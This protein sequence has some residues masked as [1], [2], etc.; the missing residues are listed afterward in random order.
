MSVEALAYVKMLEL[1]ERESTATRFVMYVLGENT[2]NDS[3]RCRLSQDQIAF[4][5]GRMSVRTLRR[6]LDTLSGIERAADGS[7]SVVE[8]V[9]IKRHPQFDST[10]ARIEDA[11]EIVGFDVWY[12]DR[13]RNRKGRSK[14][15]SQPDKMS[16]GADST[17]TGQNDLGGRPDCPGAP[18][19]ALSGG[20]GQQE[21]GHIEDRT[22]NRTSEDARLS[23]REDSISAFEVKVSQALR[24]ELGEKVFESW[25]SKVR[26]E[27]TGDI[28]RVQAPLPFVCNWIR[29][30][31]GDLVRRVC[32]AIQ[33]N[34]TSVDFIAQ[35]QGATR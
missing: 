6:H 17:T 27:T 29:Q 31:Y 16:G 2:F 13:T 10:G 19:T 28:V 34:I 32:Q 8:P 35:T 22:K 24:A 7:Q 11:I 3:F 12:L 14:N 25:F 21:S 9:F 15:D 18:D 5:A 1:G 33:S 30:H 26:F 4:E 23:A 20:T